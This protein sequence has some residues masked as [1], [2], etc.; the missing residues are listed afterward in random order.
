MQLKDLIMIGTPAPNMA[1]PLLTALTT[2][3]Y[4]ATPYLFLQG[5]GDWAINPAIGY[6]GMGIAAADGAPR[7]G[8]MQL[9]TKV[10]NKKNITSD[11]LSDHEKET[12]KVLFDLEMIDMDPLE[13]GKQKIDAV[14]HQKVPDEPYKCVLTA[15][16][17]AFFMTFMSPQINIG[18]LSALWSG[19]RD[20][21]WR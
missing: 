17:E 18:Q 2:T 13:G 7:T 3:L 19:G 20:T 9:L 14:L 11:K 21:V 1:M 6:D 4:G 10:R 8:V 12:A 15:R 5:R 16:G